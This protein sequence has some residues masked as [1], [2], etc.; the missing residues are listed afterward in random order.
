MKYLT[1]L[2]FGFS[3]LLLTGCFEVLEEIRLNDDGS[4]EITITVNGSQSKT[5]LKSIMLMDSI[6]DY[7]VPSKVDIEETIQKILSEVKQIKGVSKVSHEANYDEFIFSISC[8]FTDVDVLNNVIKHFNTEEHTRP[9]GDQFAYDAQRKVFVRNYDYNLS[10]EINRV[11][12]KDREILNDATVTTIY[13]FES[14][15]ATAKNT[16]S[17]IAGN[18]KAIM[19]KVNVPDLISDKKN[20]KNTITL[21]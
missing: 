7:K 14:Q 6:N 2:L 13:R 10:K 12:P 1:T 8:H 20:I 9:S 3:L 15:I 17:K 4:G 11:R 16:D 21:Q 5:K 19:L 18:K